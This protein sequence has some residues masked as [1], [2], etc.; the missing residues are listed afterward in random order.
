[1][2]PGALETL[3]V[4]TAVNRR[5]GAVAIGHCRGRGVSVILEC[6]MP[7]QQRGGDDLLRVEYAIGDD[8]LSI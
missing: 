3:A 8:L 1:V 5:V 6:S 7:S 2:W 4:A